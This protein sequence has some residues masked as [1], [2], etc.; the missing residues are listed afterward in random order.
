VATAATAAAPE[1]GHCRVPLSARAVPLRKRAG[2]APRLRTPPRS[3]STVPGFPQRSP[4]CL[5]ELAL[6]FSSTVYM[7]DAKAVVKKLEGIFAELFP[8]IVRYAAG[9]KESLWAIGA[10]RG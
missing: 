9:E 5:V 10:A 7:P 3:G 6:L 8:A 1:N 2:H 4:A